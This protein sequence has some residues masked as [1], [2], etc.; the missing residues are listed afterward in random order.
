VGQGL[1]TTNQVRQAAELDE[2]DLE[3]VFPGAL[4]R[5]E[6]LA[7]DATRERVEAQVGWWWHDLAVRVERGAQ[8][9]PAAVAA[10]LAA[11]LAPTAEA[12]VLADE[13]AGSFLRRLRW[14]A[15]VAPDL[16]LTL[17]NAD[18]LARLIADCCAGCRSRDE[19]LAK[20]KRDWLNAVVG[21]ATARQVDDLAP[22]AILVPTGNRI[23]LD[24]SAADATRPPILAVRL[25][26]LF[27]QPAT[28]TIAGGRVGVLL[29]LLGPNYRCEQVTRDLAS[30]WGNTYPQVRK[31]LRGRYPKHSW[32]DDPLTAPPVAKGR[33][34]AS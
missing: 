13:D 17:P 28:P 3:A 21:F 7:W 23:R 11:R 33:P 8:A 9:D 6:R 32:P 1:G 31:D 20:P 29:H 2:S 5:Q 16:G 18:D 34:R 25:Q 4:R 27:G 15:V 14:L 10:F 22:A 30:F 24:Y 19:V 12:L 26:E